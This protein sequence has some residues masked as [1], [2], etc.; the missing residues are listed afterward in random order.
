MSDGE[1]G[2]D[3]RKRVHDVLRKH[4]QIGIDPAT[5]RDDTDL[6]ESGMSSRSSVSVMLGLEGEFG[7]EFP[8]SM[9]RRDVFATVAAIC[10]AV[11]SLGAGK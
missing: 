11:T 2:A 9:L 3:V 5:L 4:A 6:Y 1:Q 10:A 8:D 7:V